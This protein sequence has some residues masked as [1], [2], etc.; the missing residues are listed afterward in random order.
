MSACSADLVC[1]CCL[2]AL[3]L[4]RDRAT[5]VASSLSSVRRGRPSMNRPQ[6]MSASAVLPSD[7]QDVD[8]GVAVASPG[9]GGVHGALV[10][11]CVGVVTTRYAVREVRV[12]RRGTGCGTVVRRVCAACSGKRA[13]SAPSCPGCWVVS[14]AE[15]LCAVC[16]VGYWIPSCGECVQYACGACAECCNAETRRG[17]HP[18]P[19]NGWTGGRQLSVSE[20]GGGTQSAVQPPSRSLTPASRRAVSSSGPVRC[21]SPLSAAPSPPSADPLSPPTMRDTAALRIERFYS[22]EHRAI[23]T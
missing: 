20:E 14:V 1:P 13:C 15:T 8:A 10:S 21:P 18:G 19:Q 23:A 22:F 11:R 7:R 6:Y 17:R 9:G 16:N 2:C 12:I 3:C 5:G 4:S